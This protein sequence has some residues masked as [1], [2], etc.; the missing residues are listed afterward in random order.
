MDI[1]IRNG[2][3]KLDESKDLRTKQNDE[4]LLKKN[5]NDSYN[6]MIPGPYYDLYDTHIHIWKPGNKICNFNGPQNPQS[7]KLVELE[8]KKTDVYCTICHKLKRYAH[9]NKNHI[10]SSNIINKIEQMQIV[11]KKNNV[12][13]ELIYNKWHKIYDRFYYK[14]KPKNII[15]DI[16]IKKK[17]NNTRWYQICY[18]LLYKPEMYPISPIE[19]KLIW[20]WNLT[21]YQKFKLNNLNY[22]DDIINDYTTKNTIKSG[23]F[24]KQNE[25]LTNFITI[26]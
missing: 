18:K 5:Y 19:T 11:T 12:N 26:E 22:K 2:K 17:I 3:I 7:I 20:P 14:I 16:K 8:H 13:I 4:G 23:I 15:Q 24:I 25:I 9:T 6:V 21:P 1:I 10:Y